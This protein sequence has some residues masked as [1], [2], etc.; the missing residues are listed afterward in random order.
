[1]KIEHSAFNLVPSLRDKLID[2]ADSEFRFLDYIDLDKRAAEAGYP[3]GWRRTDEERETLRAHFMAGRENQQVWVFAYGSLMW[4]PGFYFDEVRVGRAEGFQRKF[5]LNMTRG[6]GSE[7]TPGLMAALDAGG[8]CNGLVFRI[9]AENADHE[10]AVI[11]RREM[12]A[13][14]YRPIFVPVET[15]TGPVEAMTF[16]VDKSGDRYA[17]ELDLDTSAQM[18]ATAKGISGSNRDYADN[19]AAQLKLLGLSDP[20]FE[21]LHAKVR[22]QP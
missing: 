4:D 5:C 17:G 22:A 7:E 16:L 11:W 9:T 12:I 19:L 14:G 13:L 6:R 1:M 18:I 21:A 15:E 10:T 2:P 8:S 3:A 20:E